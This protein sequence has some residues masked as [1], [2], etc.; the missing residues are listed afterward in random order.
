MTRPWAPMPDVAASVA[1]HRSLDDAFRATVARWPD[2]IALVDKHGATRYD[3]LDR[4]VDAV[5]TQLAVQPR[6]DGPALV[7]GAHERGVVAAMLAVARVGGT[8]LVLDPTAP[9][10]H[11]AGIVARHA[12][13]AVLTDADH[14]GLAERLAPGVPLIDVGIVDTALVD[15]RV[16][17]STVPAEAPLAVS[18]TSGTSGRP[19]AVVHSSR[20]VVR[21]AER[22]GAALGITPDDVL[23]GSLPLAFVAGATPVV[24]AL[25]HGATV[26]LQ[27]L[28]DGV[29]AF[30]EAVGVHHGTVVFVTGGLITA[31]A[32]RAT[33][34][35]PS[36]RWVLTGGDTLTW[37]HVDTVRRVF[38]TARVLH[39]YNTSEA[40]WVAGVEIPAGAG[41]AAGPIP[42]GWPVPWLDVDLADD[43]GTV[44]DAAG[45]GELV[46]RGE[47]LSLGYLD[48]PALT[49]ERFATAGGRRSYRT[50]DRAVRAPDGLLRF[51]G[52]VD[53]TVKVHDT[54]VDPVRV[55]AALVAQPGVQA[56]AVV[57]AT[58]PD[59]S[60]SLR[61]FVVAPG[62]HATGIRG[63]LADALPLAMIPATV[64]VVDDLPLTAMGKVDA[65][66]LAD[67]VT[68]AGA[69][70]AAV[71]TPRTEGEAT[72]VARFGAVLGRDGIGRDDDL[73]VLGA[74]SLALEEIATGLADDLGRPVTVPMLLRHPTAADLAA[75]LRSS[76]RPRSARESHLIRVASVDGPGVPLVLFAGGGGVQLSGVARLARHVGGRRCYLV[77]PRGYEYRSRI[78]RTVP[79][80]AA[81][82]VNDWLRD[83][84]GSPVVVG[85]MSAGG[86][87]A[88]EAARQLRAAGVDVA[89]TVVLDTPPRSPHLRRGRSLRA[90]IPRNIRAGVAARRASGRGTGLLRRAYW[91]LRVI[92]ERAAIRIRAAIA[93]WTPLD[94]ARRALAFRCVVAVAL[95]RYREEPVDVDVLLVR[96]AEADPLS[97]G[98][99]PEDLRWGDYVTGALDVVTVPGVHETLVDDPFVID[100]AAAISEALRRRPR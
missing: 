61:A 66:A 10:G 2:R 72:I 9:T 89:L 19:K 29:A 58:G 47:D 54:L 97:L 1:S 31:L 78:D 24:T 100:T 85:G 76:A 17:L 37:S 62:L 15:R 4:Q 70:P 12:P 67:R 87:L 96:A 88:V 94:S 56:A 7:V 45:E 18:S 35:C 68:T 25:V 73:L 46:V 41:P 16:D 90:A 81:S 23:V 53:A 69:V 14:A 30:V 86:N 26:L 93:R 60:V 71:E 98:T 74:D 92:R 59:G 38:P 48:D 40:N 84:P 50:L 99:G 33:G 51:A 64:D 57:A 44:L 11:L 36:V 32:T 27:D 82:M 95:E 52:R 79:D 22:V 20:A 43:E 5:A 55:E 21:N 42:L 80:I 39:R 3:D 13:S 8:Y 49:A 28:S 63:A 34:E 65:R 75:V 77:L 6:D 91:A 83:H